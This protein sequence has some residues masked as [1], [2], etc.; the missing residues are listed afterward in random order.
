MRKA[1]LV[2][3]VVLVSA[4]M[5]FSYFY[6]FSKPA[7]K[8]IESTVSRI[9]DGDTVELANGDVVRL[10]GIDAPEKTQP[11]Y[12][13]IMD[14]LRKLE[15][16]TIRMEKDKTNKD[17]YGRY[18]RYVFLDDHFVNLELLQGGLAYVYIVS[19]DKKYEREFLEAESVARANEA[20]I[21]AK[22]DYSECVE[23]ETFHY[24]AKGDDTKN[25]QDEF[26]VIKNFCGNEILA[27]GWSVRNTYNSFPLPEFSLGSKSKLKIATGGGKSNAGEIF[28]SL[29]K[30]IWNNKGDTLYLRD[31]AG[32][33]ILSKSYRNE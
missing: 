8:G 27:G 24:N 3:G 20:G 6:F 17:R 12:K 32:R 26:F 11:Y 2:S 29:E 15:G 25:L 23:L 1:A 18:L 13:E 21:W 33:M 28:L 16:K 5:A 10:I 14:E 22:S 4:L 19:P 9:V 30:P 7:E 31:E